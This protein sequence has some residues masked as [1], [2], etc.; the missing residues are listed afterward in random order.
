MITVLK[1]VIHV[2]NVCKQTYEFMKCR[3][4]RKGGKA[5]TSKTLEYFLVVVKHL[6]ISK[7]A[8]ELFISQPA[9]SKQISQLETELGVTLFDRTKHALKLTRAGEVLLSETN[10]LFD[11]QDE[12]MQRVR[13]AGNVSDDTLRLCYMPG[14]LNYRVADLLAVF[15]KRY[16]DIRLELIG[17][18]PSQ[19]FSDLLNEKIEAGVILSTTTTCPEP[20]KVQTLHEA[21]LSLAVPQEHRYAGRTEIAFADITDETI[22]FLREQEAPVQHAL[23]PFFLHGSHRNYHNKIEYMPNM[24][25]IVSLIRANRGISF[26]AKDYCAATL[27]NMILI[28]ITDAMPISLNLVYNPKHVSEQLKKLQRMMR[29]VS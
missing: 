23:L 10:E 25:T 1:V 21:Q 22:L 16:S 20:L 6:S 8:K 28:P 18:L 2:M 5:M 7:A 17:G 13:D 14:A 11:K 19:I 4:M 15:Q 29:D 9:L 24:E 12:L 3:M 26:I 27:E